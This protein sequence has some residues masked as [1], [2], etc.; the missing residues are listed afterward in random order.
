MLAAQTDW[1]WNNPIVFS[2][3]MLTGVLGIWLAYRNY[4]FEKKNAIKPFSSYNTRDKVRLLTFIVL[5]LTG[6]IGLLWTM[7]LTFF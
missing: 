6:T 2:M 4:R 7:F 3:I 5:F 1:E